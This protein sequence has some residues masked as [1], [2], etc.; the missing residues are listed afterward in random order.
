MHSCNAVALAL[1]QPTSM[2]PR[3]RYN[4]TP[5]DLV[6]ALAPTVRPLGRSW[7]KYDEVQKTS[8]AKVNPDLIEKAHDVLGVLHA[9]QSNMSFNKSTISA[10]VKLL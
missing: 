3:V 5:E 4:G 8:E 6:E 2:P 1:L 10:A 7:L 9:V